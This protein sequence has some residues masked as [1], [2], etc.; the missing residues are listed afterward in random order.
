MQSNYVEP[1]KRKKILLLSDDLRAY[2]GVAVMSKEIVLN[3]VQKYRWVQLGALV[4]HPDFGK[5]VDISEDIQKETGVKDAEVRVIPSNGYG[6]QN[7]LR[8]VLAS[9]KPDAIMIFTDPRYWDWL[10]RM[11]S[12]IRTSIPIVYLDIWDNLPYPM[13][14]KP[15]YEACDGL[16]GISKQTH[17]INQVVLGKDVEN[18]VFK[19][20]PHGI[21]SK[22]YP[23]KA[24]EESM[25]YIQ[26]RDQIRGDKN[27]VLFFNARNLGRKRAADLILAWRHFCDGIGKEAAN[28]CKL[29]MHTD[30]IDNAGTD[31]IKCVQ[32]L[33]PMYNIE[34][35][36]GK[37][38]TEYMNYLYNLSDGVILPSSAEGWG[39][40]ITEAMHAGKMFAATVTGGMQDQMRFEDENGNWID[41]NQKFPTNNNM[42]YK[43]HGKWCIPIPA[44][45]GRSLVGSP[46]TPYIYDD[47]ASI[48]DI[49]KAIEQM[50]RL[51]PEERA[52][53]GMVGREWALSE[54]AGFTA[55]RMGERIIEGIEEVF[56]FREE[57][58]YKVHSLT[59][60]T[61]EDDTFI[62]FDPIDYV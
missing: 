46:T 56:T 55:E 35:D 5:I 49:A 11:E 53:R 7:I 22:I 59:E 48:R 23:I 3:T 14:N 29:L 41:F 34:L 60:I 20:I 33:C 6:D 26:V 47:R 13:W 31:L 42:T 1:K 15:Y 25:E 54:E 32:A 36:G 18:H 30:L 39:L 21:G 38:T 40:S 45:E 27:F 61:P 19:Y 44:A 62:D 10:F 12:E 51:T 8:Q 43:K 16:F 50:Y 4:Q 9:E 58:P 28:E 24:G 2:S 37:Y 57:H 17:N 52:E